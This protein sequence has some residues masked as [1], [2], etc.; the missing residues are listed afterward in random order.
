MMQTQ[1]VESLET[2]IKQLEER[3]DDA[4]KA[5][6][7]ASN[8]LAN[9]HTDF[10]ARLAESAASATMTSKELQ[11]QY[12]AMISD[13]VG[14]CQDLTKHKQFHKNPVMIIV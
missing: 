11:D 2:N 3:C 13:K 1:L 14:D 9:A 5:H 12:E 4:E 8:A 6:T 7:E 10:E